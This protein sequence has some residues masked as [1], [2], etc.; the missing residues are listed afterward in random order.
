M[1]EPFENEI[2]VWFSCRYFHQ[3]STACLNTHQYVGRW[4]SFIAQPFHPSAPNEMKFQT[5][6]VQWEKG[7]EQLR[8]LVVVVVLK[9]ALQLGRVRNA[10]HNLTQVLEKCRCDAFYMKCA[11]SFAAASESCGVFSFFRWSRLGCESSCVGSPFR[12][13]LRVCEILE[14]AHDCDTQL[15]QLSSEIYICHDVLVAS[16]IYRYVVEGF[17]QS[18]EEKTGFCVGY[19]TR[20][21]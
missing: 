17:S 5:S 14:R 10:S 21:S 20:G 7:S 13:N 18:F 12:Q 11:T 19:T 4:L 3:V 2:I 15:D 9:F 8:R 16:N 6:R 1:N